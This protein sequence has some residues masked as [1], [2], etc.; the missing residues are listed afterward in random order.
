MNGL[1]VGILKDY[2]DGLVTFW[3]ERG[4]AGDRL[5]GLYRHDGAIELVVILGLAG[6]K[7][8]VPSP[9]FFAILGSTD[10]GLPQVAR[11]DIARSVVGY[12]IIEHEQISV[13]GGTGGN[14][15]GGNLEGDIF[16]CESLIGKGRRLGLRVRTS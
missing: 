15:V 10:C 2:R 6:R 14:L 16:N 11:H 4:Q 12:G 9:Q 8:Q 7:C 5:T 3:F 13:S 1:V